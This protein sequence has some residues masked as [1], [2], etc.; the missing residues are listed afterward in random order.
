MMLKNL[1]LSQ[2]AMAQL[3]SDFV[4]WEKKMKLALGVILSLG[5]LYCE[6]AAAITIDGTNYELFASVD[7]SN[8]N[9]QLAYWRGSKYMTFIRGSSVNTPIDVTNVTLDPDLQNYN[10]AKISA[11]GTSTSAGFDSTINT[12]NVSLLDATGQTLLTATFLKSGTIDSTTVGGTAGQLN[13]SGVYTVTGGLFKTGGFALNQIYVELLFDNVTDLSSGDIWTNRGTA[14]FYRAG[15]TNNEVPEP[16]TMLL[17]GSSLA[18]LKLR[19]RSKEIS[20]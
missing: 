9:G 12:G 16:A 2:N 13:I 1:F 11:M 7:T 5:L 10:V 4:G 18:G 17:L 15:E 8:T 19:K 6:K 20:E 3:K 14:K